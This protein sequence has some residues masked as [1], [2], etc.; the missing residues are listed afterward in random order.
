M[1][2]FYDLNHLPTFRNAVITIGS[3][4]GVHCGHQKIIQRINRLAHQTDGESVLITFHPH[5]RQIVYPNDTSLRLINTLDEKIRLLERFHVD[6]IVVVPF[7]IEFSQMSA[8]EYII[9]FIVEKFAPKYIVIGY[10]HRFGLNRQGDINFLRWY[11][12]D[13]DYEV[14]EIEKQ[15]VEAISV[16]SSRIR[17]ALEK[18]DLKTTNSLLGHH[19][20]LT[21]KVVHGQK[22]GTDIGF[23]TAN[24]EIND[25]HKLI[26]P[27]GIYSV[28]V[29]HNQRS[30][31][32]MLYIGDRPTLKT[33]HNQTIEVN[34]FDFNQDIYGD[35]VIVELVD[36]IR[37]DQQFQN[38]DALADQLADDKEKA[39]ASLIAYQTGV[40]AP[41]KKT[42]QLPTVAVVILNYNGQ[43]Y[44]EKFLPA[45]LSSRY[46]ELTIYIAD[47]GSTDHSLKYV[48]N[49]YPQ[50]KCIALGVNHGFAKGYNVALEQIESDYY[51]LLNSDVEIVPGWMVSVIRYMEQ[52]ETIAACQPKIRSWHDRARFEYAGASG[53]WLDMMGYPFCR[54]RIFSDT[55]RDSGQYDQPQEIFWASGAALFIRA[56]LYHSFGG[57]DPDYIAHTEEIDLCWR[58]K[59]AGYKIVVVPEATVYHVGGG[60]LAYTS[61]RKTYLNFRNTLYT[62]FKNEPALKLLWLIPSR[63]VFDG[64]ASLLFLTQ[65]KWQ[66]I[67]SVLRAHLSFYRNIRKMAGKR[68]Y[69]A[70]LIRQNTIGPENTSGRYRGSIV[71][72]YY[73]LRKHKFKDI[74]KE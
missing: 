39:I 16:S 67:G 53:G 71:W 50:V 68:A 63:L 52:D 34:I 37:E 38:L 1:R 46:P 56:K 17:S 70:A 57:F 2:V 60:T 12:E 61:P 62:I 49:H 19:F 65:G 3:F 25:K 9:K 5:P 30:Y 51:I 4:D 43:N 44:L 22:I 29:Y 66:H 72:Q 6:N 41:K 45:L 36:F 58:L 10:D 47:N 24:I 59:R 26:P 11:G 23:P 31:K 35:E 40:V 74:A 21:G 27:K 69:Y 13:N 54:G 64:L 20:T 15:E 33:Y 55:E 7:T 14:I 48:A 8:D 28:Y 18:A 73:G 42:P 32:G